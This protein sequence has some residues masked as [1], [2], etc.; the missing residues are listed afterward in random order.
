MK[1]YIYGFGTVALALAMSGLPAVAL[2]DSNGGDGQ[3]GMNIQTEVT[4]QVREG[5]ASTSVSARVGE[6]SGLASSTERAREAMQ[7]AQEQA[8]EAVQHATEKAQEGMQHAAEKTLEMMREGMPFSLESTTTPAYTLAQLRLSIQQRLQEL[9][10]EEASSTPE[11][12]DILKNANPV[13]LAVHS[14]LASKDLLG[15][16]G[17]QVS[18]IAQQMNDSVATTTSA[19]A[20]IQSRGFFTKLFFGGDSEAAQT[21]S[22]QVAENQQRIDDLTKLLNQ[23]NVSA[24]V[25]TTLKA[26]IAAIEAAQVRLQT[27]AQK[28]QST[29]GLFSWRF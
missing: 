23:A 25:Q 24:E 10:Q 8:Q 15:G 14:L 22:Q 6:G 21:I 9:D 16:I 26:Q 13:R 12:K 20:Q 11:V 7:H 27:L 19:E 1:K 5:S 2:A 18:V 4:A 17:A 28:E 29:W 3:G